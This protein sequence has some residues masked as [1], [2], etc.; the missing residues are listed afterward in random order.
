[1]EL[2]AVH[3]MEQETKLELGVQTGLWQM[4]EPTARKI[5]PKTRVV[6]LNV[7]VLKH[8]IVQ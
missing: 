2:P 6:I 7:Q 8:Y 5:R 1:M 4:G 3:V